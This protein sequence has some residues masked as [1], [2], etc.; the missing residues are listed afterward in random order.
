MKNAGQSFENF[1][2]KDKADSLERQAFLSE[3]EATKLRDAVGLALGFIEDELAAV[4]Q[5]RPEPTDPMWSAWESTVNRYN[6]AL[7]TI[8]GLM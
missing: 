5:N 6:R 4:K 2:L 3:A 8:R 1:S 7:A